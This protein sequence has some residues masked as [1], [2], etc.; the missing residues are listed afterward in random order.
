MPTELDLEDILEDIKKGCCILILGPDLVSYPNNQ[1]FFEVMCQELQTDI[2]LNGEIDVGPQYIFTHEEL[3][4]LKNPAKVTP[5]YRR[6]N[7]FYN[8]RTEFDA[9]FAKIA[10]IPFPLMVSLL[11]DQRLA[12]VFEEKQLDFQFKHYP[13]E[14]NPEAVD[15]PTPLRP[16]IYNILGLADEDDGILTFDHLFTYLEGIL[17]TRPLPQALR[18]ALDKARTFLFLGVHFEKWYM[19]VLLKLLIGKKHPEKFSLL[20]NGYINEVNTFIARRLELQFLEVEPLDFLNELYQQCAKEGILRSQ[21]GRPSKARVFLSYSHRDKETADQLGEYLTQE[22]IE[23]IRDIDNMYGGQ[24]IETFIASNINQVDCVLAIISENSLRSG[25]VSKELMIT[26]ERAGKYLL[27]C[28]LD[29]SFEQPDF[30][31]KSLVVIQQS[32]DGIKQEMTER[33][34]RELHIDDLYRKYRLLTD[35]R[36]NLPTIIAKLQNIK[37]ISCQPDNLERNKSLIATYILQNK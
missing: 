32:L 16:L 18:E 11:P 4:Q 34:E 33:K 10:G 24:D 20:K 35:L 5:L 25:W 30:I 2:R 15:K 17:G 27:P 14:K 1:S 37:C 28:C 19:Q 21:Q 13:R 31:S 12:S 9:P 3:I 23:V 36:Y 7:K 22:R 6:V 26:I 29:Y 8:N